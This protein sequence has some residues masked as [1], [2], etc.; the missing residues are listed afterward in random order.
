MMRTMPRLS[1]AACA[2]T[3]AAKG[4]MMAS[5]SIVAQDA[6]DPLVAHVGPV[7]LARQG[8]GEV[9]RLALRTSGM[10]A[11]SRAKLSRCVLR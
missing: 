8:G 10:V 6:R 7:R 9:I 4:A 3:S 1:A 5:G 11:T 2:S